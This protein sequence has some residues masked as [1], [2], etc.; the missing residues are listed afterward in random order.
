MHNQLKEESVGLEREKTPFICNELTVRVVLNRPDMEEK[1]AN[2][3][4]NTSKQW[5]KSRPNIIWSY[6]QTPEESAIAR[7]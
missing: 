7:R 3:H 5:K 6:L 1:I 2:F 4:E